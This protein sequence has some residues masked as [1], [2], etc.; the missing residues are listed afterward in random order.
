VQIAIIGAGIG[1]LTA[2]AFLERDGHEVS[3]FE[4]AQQ[5]GEVGAGI[6][7]SPNGSR[8]L[9]SLGLERELA[10]IGT[11]PN[12]VVIRRWADDSVL[13]ETPLGRSATDRWGAPYF[14]VYRPDVI[15]LLRRGI[16]RSP[17]HLGHRVDRLDQGGSRPTV[18]F[19]NGRSFSADLVIGADGI[20][21]RVRQ[22]LFGE[23]PTRFSGWVAY[24][25]LVPRAAIPEFE[26]EVTN[27]LGPDAHI[28]SYFV[29][30]EQRYL[31]LV[32]ISHDP[33]WSIESWN[34]PGDKEVL[35]SRHSEWSDT[36]RRLLA[37]VET[38]VF[39]WALHDRQ[40]LPDWS[41]GAITLLGDAAHPMVPFMAQGACQ[42]IEDSAALSRA[43]R[44]TSD[45]PTSLALYETARRPRT[46][47]I[48]GRSF[49]NATTFHFADGPEQIRRDEGYA[50]VS[51]LGDASLANFDWL[52]GHDALTAPLS[53]TSD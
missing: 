34:E 29:G 37:Q 18:V 39:R 44:A 15:E 41:R 20:H 47:A 9:H 46:A 2:A 10:E 17:I 36:V 13:S 8:L 21:S 49:A 12:R 53:A 50:K 19:E 27:R 23:Q 14:N 48:Q 24:R 1:G 4:S 16:Q 11:T 6:Q 30:R 45:V 51:S 40:P 33:Q 3:V 52:Y 25:A 5:L 35:Q 22:E 43:L 38:S 28:V 42:A 31:N 32:C 26:V 7:I